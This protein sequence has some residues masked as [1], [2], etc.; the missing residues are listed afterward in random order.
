MENRQ[1]LPFER[2]RYYVGKLLTSA[3]FQAEQAYFNNKRRFLNQ[4]MFGSGI[5]CGLSVYSL[6]DLSVMIESGAAI[7]GLGREIVVE[8]SVVRK[9]SAIEGFE[10]LASEHAAL[11]LR[12][13]EEAV[14]PVCTVNRMERDEEYELNRLREGWELFLMDAQELEQPEGLEE[15]SEF[16]LQSPLYE[17]ADFSVTVMLPAVV[18][19]GSAV[20]VLV[21]VRKLSESAKKLSLDCVLQAPAFLAAGGGHEV[22]IR[23]VDLDLQKDEVFDC[24]CWLTAQQPSAEA[25]VLAKTDAVRIT[26]G[27]EEKA[28]HDAFLIKSSI[29]SDSVEEILSREVG[30]VSLESRSFSAL[31]E[32]IQLADITLQLTKNA[33]IIDRVEECGVKK[34]LYTTSGEETRRAYEAWFAPSESKAAP[35]PASQ[36]GTDGVSAGLSYQT[37]L[38]ATGTC[39]IPLGDRARRGETFY[40][41]EIMHGLGAGNVHVEVGFEYLVEDSRLSTTAKNTIYG[42]A[43]LF[44]QENPPVPLAQTAVKVMN[45]RGSFVVAARLQKDT[46]YVMLLVRWVAV[47]IPSEDDH[48]L[49]QRISDKSISAVQP[50]V[51]L[52]TRESCYFSVRFRNMEPCGLI[53]ELTDRDSGEITPDGVYTAPAREGVY[54]IRISCADAPLI[55]TYAYA[56]VKKKEHRDGDA[57]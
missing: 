40:S 55:C 15:Q 27:G 11:C 53:Y 35:A 56:I 3:D 30:R 37:P 52:G 22:R 44:D 24:P 50:T 19:A 54:E 21:R 18:S 13:H 23:A 48:T 6:D 47:K 32:Y 41:S 57:S 2:N 51:L 14:H 38:Y 9:L 1:L 16:L 7:D 17:D 42:D 43:S 25:V 29:S 4:M 12:Y 39:E 28:P 26:V 31:P 36:N 8:N 10:T 34:Y 20:R 46:S 5:I 49:L 33:Y 45:D